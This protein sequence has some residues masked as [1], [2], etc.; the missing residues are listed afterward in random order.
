MSKQEMMQAQ[1]RETSYLMEAKD[2]MLVR[3]PESKLEAWQ[4]AQAEDRPLTEQER[5]LKERI[6]SMLYGT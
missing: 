3:V 5:L 4:Q 2:G 1:P 6:V